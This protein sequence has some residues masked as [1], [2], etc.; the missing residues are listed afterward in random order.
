MVTVLSGADPLQIHLAQDLLARH[1]I[2]SA[3]L[4]ENAYYLG[5]NILV[6]LVV[7]AA[8]VKRAISVL[9]E[10]DVRFG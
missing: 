2:R 5:H 8:A 9:A 1:G 4:D 7:P 3:I 10:V 6:R